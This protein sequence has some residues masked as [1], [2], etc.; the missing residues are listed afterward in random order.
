MEKSNFLFFKNAKTKSVFLEIV[1][2][3]LSFLL[4]CA[5][6]LIIYSVNNIHPFGNNTIMMIDMKSQYI[7]Y[8]RYYKGILNGENNSIYTLSKVFGGDFMSI[9]TYYLASPFNL[10]IVFYPYNNIP[11]FFVLINTLKMCFAGLNMYLLLRFTSTKKTKYQYLL[12]AIAYSLISYSVIYTSNYMWLDG[13]MV[14]PIIILG[15]LKLEENKHYWI[16]IISLGY[17]LFS[18][19]YIG[20][21]ICIFVVLFFIYRLVCIDGDFKS[22]L[23]YCLRFVIFSLIAGLLG[24]ASWITAFYHFGGTKAVF[25]FGEF[26]V[27]SFLPIVT[28]FLENNFY[29]TDSISMNSGYF[30]MFTSIITLV[31]FQLFFFN[32]KFNKKER[33]GGFCLFLFYVL[34]SLFSPT[35]I[36]LHGGR[37]PTWFPGR[38]AFLIGFIV[39]YFASKEVDEINDTPLYSSFIPLATGIIFTI[40]LLTVKYQI[41]NNV[42]GLYDYSIVSSILYF[43]TSILLIVYLFLLKK[44]EFK[45]KEI[46]QYSVIAI[47][48]CLTAFSSFRGANHSYNKMQPKVENIDTYRLD[49][50]YSKDFENIKSL[51]PYKTYRMEAT[52]NRPGTDNSIN[53][54]PLFYS[55]NGLSH[56][57]SN[58]KKEVQEFML[59]L[60]FHYNGFFEK[61]DSGS[62][63]AINSFLNIK[64]LIDGDIDSTVKPLFI[65]NYPYQEITSLESENNFKYYKND[66]TLSL[67]FVTNNQSSERVID[68]STNPDGST[69]W[70]DHFEYQNSMYKM[71]TNSVKDSDG[72]SKDIFTKIK[73]TSITTSG[74]ISYVTKEDGLNYYTGKAGST[75]KITYDGSDIPNNYN[76]YFLEKNYSED[77]SYYINNTRIE[78][79]TYWNKGIKPIKHSDTGM[80]ELKMTLKNDI[81]DKYIR[82]EFYY[83]NTDI[84]KEYVDQINSQ[85]V[86]DFK[87][88]TKFAKSGFEATFDIQKENQQIMFTIPY[89]KGMQIY[90]DGKK[91]NTVKRMT[92]FSSTDI[93]NLTIGK[94]NVQIIYK[95]NGYFIGYTCTLLGVIFTITSILFYSKLEDRIFKK[96]KEN[97]N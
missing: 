26:K 3:L 51:E 64:Y 96:K 59:M 58:E 77:V 21:I 7:S 1:I 56:Y 19:W 78:I 73:Q 46:S 16:Y 27:Y 23:P 82:D 93:D 63:A 72:N 20:S 97:E 15:L 22:K 36:L 5:I 84:L 13:V 41:N 60:G 33:I 67:G 85:K 40:I 83:E 81:T 70:F 62:T 31:L 11:D 69:H 24:G 87:T 37:E 76:L 95:D 92:I 43:S 80:Y 68:Y 9:F 53:N 18:N 65:N 79:S 17:A 29:S 50:S 44:T 88:I 25:S 94:H 8:L 6:L 55:Y 71:I 34:C 12:F 54:N 57:S 32:N 66:K 49:D 89:E 47:L 30:S 52:F 48:V 39:V 28:G 90:L 86:T 74:D 45:Y 91:V 38:Y 14:L 75:I 2:G 42:Y 4:P 61:Y 35:Y 10:F